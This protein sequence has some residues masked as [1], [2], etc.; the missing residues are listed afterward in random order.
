MTERTRI[1]IEAL[2]EER[3][4]HL[5][6][7]VI[8]PTGWAW[9]Q[10]YTD[11]IDRAWQEIWTEVAAQFAK[12]PLLSIVA[13]GGYGRKEMSP[14]S[15]IDIAIIPLQETPQEAEANKAIYFIANEAFKKN[16]KI[17]ISNVYRVTADIAGLDSIDLTNVLDSRLIAGA[18][19]PFQNYRA[20]IWRNFP[21]ADF[22]HAKLEERK[23]EH[24]RTH[25]SP[26]VSQPNLKQG[27]GGLRD[28]HAY[29]WIGYAIGERPIP[30][31]SAVDQLLKFRNLLHYH[32]GSLNDDLNFARRDE[33]AATLQ[34]DP[35][36]LG[37][38][39]AEILQSNHNLFN[40]GLFRLTENRYQLAPFAEAARGELRI[41][42]HAPAGK[43]AVV[44]SQ[45]HGIGLDLSTSL[46][47]LDPLVE[48]DVLSALTSSVETLRAIQATGIFQTVFP[49]LEACQFLMPRDASHEY[50]VLEHTFKCLEEYENIPIT[51]PLFEIKSSLV[52]PTLQ[53]LAIL[54]HD[55]GKAIPLGRHQDTGADLV[56]RVGERWSLEE[57]LVESLHWLVK[58]H[59]LMSKFIQVRDIDHPETIAEFV[60]LIPD[61]EH[62]NNLTLLTYC[63][64]R[65]VNPSIW[66]PVQETYLL[67][68]HQRAAQ[69][70]LN[71]EQSDSLENST[72]RRVL[73]KARGT[74]PK[75]LSDIEEFLSIMPPRYLLSTSE[76]T[77]LEHHTLYSQVD[78][79]PIIVDFQ[80]HNNMNLT[81]I[82]VIAH[83]QKGILLNILGTLY[84]QQL[85]IQNLRCTTTESDPAIIIDSF[86]VSKA[87]RPIP[88]HLRQKI[89][90]DLK[91][92]LTGTK[93][94]S[95]LLRSRSKDPDR[96]QQ[97]FTIE[98]TDRDPVIIDIRA[99]RGR[100]LAYRLTKVISEHGLSVVSA[101]LG[102]WAGSASAGFYV[103]HPEGKKIN[104]AALKR[105]FNNSKKNP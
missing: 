51:S 74:T 103:V 98:V 21:T 97:L 91:A 42:P 47:I 66:T 75:L 49:E 14:H 67:T 13:T 71:S 33:L 24:L 82:T 15:D 34:T 2:A 100:G 32:A 10:S 52:D 63:D 18:T 41:A 90:S 81:E 89:E 68:L 23:S 31:T 26:L 43:I 38:E 84:A 62:L 3:E 87:G 79:H 6:K 80:D 40:S 70:L 102:Q 48:P 17:K 45:A 78:E 61:L 29:N 35:F 94:T 4:R 105:A 5:A 12:P 9:C 88:S 50:T 53:I 19:A 76:E 95:D 101:R 85:S 86:L 64:V 92:V 22:L 104:I 37:A 57:S 11:I 25:S 65:S 72:I 1:A 58:N 8:N 73:R 30:P 36:A 44:M 55:L 93:S 20:E 99:P 16:L 83:D 27:A 39:I 59:L 28:F 69:L 60:G 96:K 54:F 46:P 7:L 56:A 77:I